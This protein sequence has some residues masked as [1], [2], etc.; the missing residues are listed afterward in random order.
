[1]RSCRAFATLGLALILCVFLAACGGGSKPA[2]PVPPAIFESSLP[3]GA[4]NVPYSAAVHVTNGTG[5]SPFT[6]S[7]TSGSLPAGLSLDSGTGAITGTPTTIVNATFTVQVTDAKSLTGSKTLSI[8]IRGA[9][10]ITPPTL[11]GGTVGTPYLATLTATGGVLPYTWSVS[12]G[13]LPAGLTLTTNADSTATISGTPTTLGTSTFSIQVADAEPPPA[14]GTSG[15]LSVYIEG[16]LTITTTSLP[17][18]NVAIF[19]DSQLMATGGQTPYTWSITSGTLPPG[20]SLTPSTGMISGTPTTTGSYPITVQVTDADSNTA[21]ANLSITITGKLQG[22]FAFSFNG[23]NN[24]QPFYTAGSFTGDGAGN[25][26]GVLD[27]NGLGA[28]GVITKSPFTG[29]YS[30]GSSGLGTL[31]FTIPA[32]GVTYTYD[33]AASLTGDTKFILADS[34]HPQIYGSGVIKAQSLASLTGLTSLSGNYAMGFFGVDPTGNRSAGA[35]AFEADSSGNLTRGVED[36][37]DNGTVHSQTAFTGSWALD[38]NFATTGRGTATLNV[39]ANARHYA[40]YVVNPKSELSEVQTDPVSGG[41]SLSLVSVLKQLQGSVNGSFSDR[42]L[43]SSTV[44]ELNGVSS[45][46]PDV[47]LGVS[48]FDGAGHITLFQ[49]DENNAGMHTV[50]T[51]TGGT[52]NVPSGSTNGRTT[53]AGLGT[54]QPVFYLVNANRGFFIGTDS[55]V[56]QGSFEAQAGAPF[57]LPSFL[58]S[59]AGG[60][61][62]PVST[63][64]T[65]ET[66]STTIPAPGGTMVVTYDVSG[67][68]GQLIDQMLSSTY[69]LGDDPGG[70]GMNTTGKLILTAVGSPVPTAIVYMIN[71][72]PNPTGG[73]AIDRTNNK[74]ASINIAT[75]SGAADPNSRLTVVQSTHQ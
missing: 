73:G 18:G 45:T 63:S 71:E 59:Y 38:A 50:N 48:Q 43:N 29:T 3:N 66:D 64:V 20:L 27:Q 26:R 25:L 49:T 6:W 15:P 31:T 11:P 19:Y 36:T 54:F 67:P 70:T 55:S 28:P 30:I 32:L 35:G 4:V 42:S 12:S 8:N 34:T 74:W 9:V 22:T 1:M 23:F 16:S 13:S 5:T 65:N 56:T 61:I 53:V 40:F 75:P 57:S 39:G 17:A 10:S 72:V 7:I 68:A 60:T 2:P 41:A 46:G 69:A 24:G 37:N 33:F 52:Y 51:F 58:Q 62:Q 21:S 44:M 14:T 47:Q